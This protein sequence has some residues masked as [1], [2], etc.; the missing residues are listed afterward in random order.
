[1]YKHVPKVSIYFK[2]KR[3]ITINLKS[4]IFMNSTYACYI[5][6]L[7]LMHILNESKQESNFQKSIQSSTTPD[8]DHHMGK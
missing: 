2:Y 8:P 1:M 6:L 7:I 5:A 4:T 3:T